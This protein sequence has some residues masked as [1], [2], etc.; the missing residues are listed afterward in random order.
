M[1][2]RHLVKSCCNSKS[3]IF[4]TE[5]PVNKSHLQ[6]FVKAGYLTPEHYTKSGMFYVQFKGL[7]AQGAYGNNK[8]QVK[9]NSGR[10]QQLL[11]SFA[12][13]LDQCTHK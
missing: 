7:V 13:L 5:K 12:N 11:N 4:E 10:C 1:I 3:Y 6:T 8:I 9:C 2:K